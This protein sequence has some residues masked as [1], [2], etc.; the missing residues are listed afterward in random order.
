MISFGAIAVS[1][2]VFAILPITSIILWL[3]ALVSILKSNFKDNVTRVMWMVLVLVLP[4]IGAILY[5]YIG[6]KQRI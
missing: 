5:F 4:V 2:I 6:K 3:L 1:G